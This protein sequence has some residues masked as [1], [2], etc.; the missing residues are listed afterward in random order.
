MFVETRCNLS[1]IY[2]LNC[3][4][5]KQ[6]YKYLVNKKIHYDIT[7]LI[8]FKWKLSLVSELS[9]DRIIFFFF[10]YLFFPFQFYWD[11]IYIQ[12]CI[13]LYSIMQHN[14]LTYMH[15]EMIDLQHWV[16]SWSVQHSDSLFLYPTKWSP[17]TF[18]YLYSP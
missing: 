15:H 13:T 8:V 17:L 11:I 9:F 12:H 16:S 5:P 3:I 4:L 10:F 7:I 6:A 2:L 18:F 1:E 14:D